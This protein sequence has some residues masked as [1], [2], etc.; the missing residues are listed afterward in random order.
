MFIWIL[1]GVYSIFGA[2]SYAELGKIFFKNIIK[3]L[4]H[5]LFTILFKK[6]CMIP[7]TGGEYEY[8]KVNSDL[9][10]KKLERTYNL[11]KLI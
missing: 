9:K 5:F 4:N 8:F 6:G 7:K 1:C 11:I 2:L 10:K 3:S